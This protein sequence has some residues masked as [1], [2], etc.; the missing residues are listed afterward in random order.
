MLLRLVLIFP[1][2]VSEE[3]ERRRDLEFEVSGE[4]FDWGTFGKVES[5][6]GVREMSEETR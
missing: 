1:Q 3:S 5:V 6:K 2:G 4:D